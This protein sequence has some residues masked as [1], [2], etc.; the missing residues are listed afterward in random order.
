MKLEFEQPLEIYFTKDHVILV[1][2]GE[3][4]VVSTIHNLVSE[5]GLRP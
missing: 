3:T 2:N 1:L 5:I 4:V